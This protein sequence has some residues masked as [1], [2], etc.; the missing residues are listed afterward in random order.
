MQFL[1]D[2]VQLNNGGF[3]VRLPADLDGLTLDNEF[4]FVKWQGKEQKIRLHDYG[5]IYKI[6][7]L[8]EYVLSHLLKCVSPEVVAKLLIANVIKSGEKLADLNV[9]DFGA[10]SGLAGEILTY[11]GVKSIVGIDIIEE[12]AMAAQR[13]RPG[14]YSGYYIEDICNLNHEARKML[15]SKRFN[16]LICVSS[17]AH[18]HILPDAFIHAFNF[19]TQKGWIA[20]NLLRNFFEQRTPAGSFSIFHEIIE[21]DILEVKI[22]H[23]YRHRLLMDGTAIENVAII[24]RKHGN[25]TL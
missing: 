16:C 24:G 11:K 7:G 13:D 21:S 10:G 2:N 8:Y 20:L 17:L 19:I 23:P 6:P 14:V 15:K 3:H 18:G 25:I 9:L 22:I 4:F 5:E 12:A 1:G